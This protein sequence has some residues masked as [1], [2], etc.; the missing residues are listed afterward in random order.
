M[1]DMR[2]GMGIV[3]MRT[4]ARIARLGPQTCCDLA[5][6]CIELALANRRLALACGNGSLLNLLHAG[7]P[8][9]T[10]TMLT[11][12]QSR[13]IER[14]SFA[15]IQAGARMPWRSDCL[16]QALA[17]RRWL[18]G[19]GIE[20]EI[21]IGVLREAK[22]GFEAHAWLEAGGKVILGGDISAYARFAV[23]D[24]ERSVRQ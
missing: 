6:A 9:E 3:P 17:A 1:G 24:T 12:R 4:V 23:S 18:A 7:R 11:Q 15:L 2:Q 19:A 13:Q 8:A 10:G 5:R 21:S 20:S 14:I 16:V 22:A